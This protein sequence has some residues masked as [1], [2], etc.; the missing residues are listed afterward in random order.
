MYHKIPDRRTAIMDLTWAAWLP[1]ALLG[2]LVIPRILAMPTQYG[3]NIS[4]AISKRGL[5]DF[6]T[7]QGCKVISGNDLDSYSPYDDISKCPG[8][9]FQWVRPA[10]SLSPGEQE[11]LAKR[12]PQLQK[13]WDQRMKDVGLESP[14]PE[15]RLPVVAMAL[16]GGGYRAMISGS[17]MA[18][19]QNDTAG[20]V[21]NILSVS[22]YMAGLSGGSW[23]VASY[24]T[25]NGRGPVD[26]ANHVRNFSPA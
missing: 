19:Q 13:A 24:I 17:G 20:S 4:E 23:A 12:R 8:D 5:E 15:G 14:L 16:S 9:D 25:N 11:Y 2:L 1:L 3:A 21:G 26:L 18:F 7:H 6:S 10:D 22:S